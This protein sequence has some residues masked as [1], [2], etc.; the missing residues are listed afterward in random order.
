MNGTPPEKPDRSADREKP[1]RIEEAR[2]IIKEYADDLRE[3]I[4]RLLRQ[5]N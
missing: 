3:I 5:F 2:Q 4:K 1:S